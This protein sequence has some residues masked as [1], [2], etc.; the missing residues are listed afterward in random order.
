MN[1]DEKISI[2]WVSGAQIYNKFAR[3]IIEI[4]R[5]FPIYDVISVTSPNVAF[6]RHHLA[7]HFLTT[8]SQWLFMVDTDL[9]INPIDFQKLIQAADWQKYP[10]L[11]GKYFLYFS[12]DTPPFH[13]SCNVIN[14]EGKSVWLVDYPQDTLV[15]IS[16]AAG[17]YMLIHRSVF[18][19]ILAD[20]PTAAQP[21]FKSYIKDNG[22]LCP[23]DT[24]FSEQV[25]KS[26]FQ[27]YVHT[28]ANSEHLGKMPVTETDYLRALNES[29]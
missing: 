17:G 24:Y 14:E 19:K 29:R 4:V 7:K 27:M 3:G 11:S 8:D 25:N 28:G 15:P 18:E 20:N 9:V 6:N 12:N 21:W 10:I 1:S 22:D 13:L 5:N 23:E 16:G 26:G 2:G